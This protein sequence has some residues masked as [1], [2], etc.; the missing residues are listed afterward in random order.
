MSGVHGPT[1][2]SGGSV[3]HAANG[4][5]PRTLLRDFDYGH[6]SVGADGRTVREWEVIAEDREIEVAPGVRFQAWTFNGR[7]PGPT[8]RCTEGDLLRVRFVNRSEHPHTM[9]FHG[10][11]TADMDGVPMLGRGIISPAKSSPTPS[12]PNHSGCISTTATWGPWPSTSPAACTARSSS[13]RKQGA[14]LLTSW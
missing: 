5:D 12:T 2:R 11:H 9:H 8:L 14:R 4:F 7:I 3:D 10:I 6:A 13:T 1:F